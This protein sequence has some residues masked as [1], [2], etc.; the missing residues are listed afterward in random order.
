MGSSS[1]YL[2]SQLGLPG[3][4]RHDQRRYKGAGHNAPPAGIASRARRSFSAPTPSRWLSRRRS[5]DVVWSIECTEHLFDKPRFFRRAGHLAAARRAR[6]HLRLAGRRDTDR[7]RRHAAGPSSLRRLLLPVAG[8]GGR[9][10]QRGWRKPALRRVRFLD[11]TAAV[12]RTWEICQERVRRTGVRWLARAVD[13]NQVLF[14]DRFEAILQA[15]QTG[16]MQYGCFIAER[17]R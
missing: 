17:A 12:T 3:D 14:L 9:L 6:G 11:W 5:F 8:N 7:L 2:A 13:Q 4:G 16:A 1:I 10:S 15:Y